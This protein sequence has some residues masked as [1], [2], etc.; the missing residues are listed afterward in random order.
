MAVALDRLKTLGPLGARH[1]RILRFRDGATMSSSGRRRGQEVGVPLALG[2]RF[3]SYEI[4]SALGAGGM[5]EVYRARDLDLGRDVA[6]KI[7]PDAFAHD[8]DRLMRF[9]REAQMLAALSHPNVAAI[10]GVEQASGVNGLV[11]EL[12]D[13]V[14]LADIVSGTPPRT[15]SVTEVLAVAGQIA[16][17]LEA[18]HERG[19]IHRDLKP[20]NIKVRDDGV[21]KVLDFGLA[22]SVDEVALDARAPTMT[23]PAVTESGII[24][25]TA[26]YMS[27]EQ[28]RGRPAD[29]RADIWAFGVVLYELL[30]RQRLFRGRLVTE[31]IADV[32]TKEPD[33][34]AVP[35]ETP[36][37]VV[38]LL[39]RCLI[40][41]PK[42]RLRDIGEA[43][44]AIAE[45]LAHPER[46]AAERVAPARPSWTRF[47]PIAAGS[48]VGAVGIVAA[49]FLQPADVIESAAVPTTRTTIELPGALEFRATSSTRFA[50]SPDGRRLVYKAESSGASRLYLREMHLA[51]E[52]R[53]I[54]GTEGTASFTLS[55]G[56]EWLAFSVGA[57]LKKVPLAGG[58]PIQFCNCGVSAGMFWSPDGFVY[59][60]GY[61]EKIWTMRRIAESGG[62]VEPVGGDLEDRQ[63]THP[64]PLPGGRLL[65]VLS[66]GTGGAVVSPSIAAYDLASGTL[67]P[68]LKRGTEPRY[69]PSG[70]LAFVD[71]QMLYAVPFDA[72]T[73][74]VTGQ[75]A[76]L[77]AHVSV[78]AR[79]NIAEY[80]VSDSGTIVYGEGRFTTATVVKLGANGSPEPVLALP[81]GY[82][83]IA[84]S[85]DGRRLALTVDPRGI[86]VST[87]QYQ[88]D[89]Y[90][91]ELDLGD[92]TKRMAGETRGAVFEPG[93]RRLAF[94]AGGGDA[95]W[96]IN[97]GEDTFDA[98]FAQKDSRP[99]RPASFSPDG[100]RLAYDHNGNLYVLPLDGDRTPQEFLRSPFSQTAPMFSPDGRWIAYVLSD[101]RGG[102]P[103]IWVRP[104]PG[105]EPAVRVST[106][107]G[108]QPQ[109][110]ADGSRLYFLTHGHRDGA[111]G[112]GRIM[113][114]DVT[115]GDTFSAR[116]PVPV[117]EITERVRA[118]APAPDGRTFYA[119]VEDAGAP[120]K[121]GITVVTG[122]F[123][124]VRKL[125]GGPR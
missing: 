36:R 65:V 12:V 114:A 22:K 104:Y 96:T 13:G 93:R 1:G 110:A 20:A 49:G 50:L 105:P 56:G 25:G 121:R 60:P 90:T 27:P 28:A 29:K 2:S 118:F 53:E 61:A 4:I 7:L 32:L 52:A 41:D 97:I 39:K 111:L 83:D 70:H 107:G 102:R 54:P 30:T 123:D 69:L 86:P 63:A 8:P 11:M 103:D 113:A 26:E 78:G 58:Q 44:I 3:G 48:A 19:I 14:T 109:W 40:K 57:G 99:I 115:A 37:P 108:V 82:L 46:A 75:P 43:R 17:A 73:L 112:D 23:S 120:V 71:R 125:A 24:L 122:W 106:G 62:T 89:L 38:A 31:A 81:R 88:T 42:N 124:E 34:D 59:F 85:G 79:Y 74:K 117:V 87:V 80:A 94:A 95:G 98:V 9:Q 92:F 18:A 66:E 5:G 68:I 119:I 84:V 51:G 6:I 21:V 116:P 33:W 77:I 10:H 15:L 47:W 35:A 67:T 100:R 91:S 72:A 55:P 16:E 76:P 101:G 45:C 64:A